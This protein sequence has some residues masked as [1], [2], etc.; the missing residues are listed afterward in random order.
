M[1]ISGSKIIIEA[2]ECEKL[3]VTAEAE[4]DMTP[5]AGEYVRIW[6]DQDG[7]YSLD[8]S[9]SHFWQIAELRVPELQ[10]QEIDTGEVD[11]FGE[12]ITMREALPLD[13]S[14]TVVAAWELPA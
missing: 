6:L 10:Y 1:K 11:E 12:P 9:T 8:S 14:E 13:L 4:I 2:F 3:G 5:Y 7:I